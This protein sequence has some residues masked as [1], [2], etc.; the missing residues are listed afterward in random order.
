GAQAA[1]WKKKTDAAELKVN[2]DSYLRMID[3]L[4]YGED[5]KQGFVEN[6]A[7]YHPVL[8]FQF[9]I[10]SKWAYQ[11]T[12]QQF[13]M[14]AENGSA[15]ML[16]T[17]VQSTGTLED[18]ANALLQ[19]NQ[20]TPSE[21][22]RDNLNG[23]PVY[24]IVADLASQQQGQQGIRALINLIE[25]GGNRY[26]MLGASSSNDFSQH[27]TTFQHTMNNFKILTDPDKLNRQP[28]R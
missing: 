7:F 4:V 26:A 15:M 20:L 17:L 5:P 24:K 9:P 23:L 16:L 21:A 6:N 10:P 8:K 19:N 18:A 25:Y 11:N 14:A 2:A 28:E 3:G 12:P 1:K 13:Q 27:V 22:K